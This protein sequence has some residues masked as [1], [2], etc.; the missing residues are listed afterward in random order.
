MMALRSP[1]QNSAELFAVPGTLKGNELKLNLPTGRMRSIAVKGQTAVWFVVLTLLGIWPALTNR[2]PIFYPDTT[3]YM[4][5]ADLAISKVLGVQ[6][7]TDWARD[8]RRIIELETPVPNPRSHAGAQ[9]PSQRIV[10]AGRSIIYGALLYF[11]EVL[12]R[13]W[14]SIIIQSLIATYL[15]FVFLVRTLDLSFRHFVIVC[16]ILFIATPLPFFNSFLMPDVFAGLLILGFAILATSWSRLNLFDR[17]S[18][19]AI[20]VFAVLTHITHLCLLIGLAVITITYFAIVGRSPWIDIRRLTAIVAAFVAI[21]VA[22]ELTFSLAVRR[23]IG[24][25]PIRPPFVTAKLVSMLGKTAVSRVCNST[26]FVVCKFQ[27]RL[28]L[29]TDSFLWSED[30]RTGVFSAVDVETKRA[31]GEEQW[32][33]ALAIIPQ[34]LKHIIRGVFVDGLRQLTHIGLSE[35]SY[36]PSALAFFKD[37]LPNQHFDKM[38][39]TPAARSQVYVLFG[40]YVLYGTTAVA[41]ILIVWLLQ[42][43]VHIDT[44]QIA[45]IEGQRR[46]IWLVATYIQFVGMILNAVICG[47]F[48]AVHD[49]YQARVIWLVVLSLIAGIFLTEPQYRF[50]LLWNRKRTGELLQG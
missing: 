39:S 36:A 24:S 46:M 35:Y 43:G 23:I 1:T 22:W 42:F 30:E 26:I 45:N 10:L 9:K 37:R 14:F 2:Q 27:D 13:M 34:N 15:I 18:V 4:R 6:F 44:A 33:F 8:Q 12:D 7:A 32:R 38:R 21:A 48:S 50:S 11:G 19:S 28:P 40:R 47:A 17:W 31:L 3:A 25:P 49:R 29:N 16:V 41:T 5:G 20:S